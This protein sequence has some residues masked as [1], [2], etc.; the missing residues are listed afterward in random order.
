[1]NQARP[2]GA[3]LIIQ[4]YALKIRGGVDAYQNL[5]VVAVQCRLLLLSV[6][7]KRKC[8]GIILSWGRLVVN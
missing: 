6:R 2:E 4:D 5:H 8:T 3:T 1:M 7:Y